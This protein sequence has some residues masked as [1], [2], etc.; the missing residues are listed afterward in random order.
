[1]AFL[2]FYMNLYNNFS[3]ISCEFQFIALGWI[4]KSR[5]DKLNEELEELYSKDYLDNGRYVFY[6]LNIIRVILENKWRIR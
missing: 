5:F 2:M 1:M 3:V 6:I 4:M